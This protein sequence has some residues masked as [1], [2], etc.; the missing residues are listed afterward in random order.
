[1][2]YPVPAGA[3]A[4]PAGPMPMGRKRGGRAEYKLEDGAGGGKGRLEKIDWYGKK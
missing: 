3:G 2:P 4:P 1:M